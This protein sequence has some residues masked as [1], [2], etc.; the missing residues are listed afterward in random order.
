MNPQIPKNI[1]LVALDLDDTTLRTDKRI[2]PVTKSALEKA[3]AAGIELVVASGRA[4]STLPREILSIPGIRYAIT[5]NG[6]ALYHIPTGR[7]LQHYP[8]SR[9]SI[10]AL[11][12]IIAEASVLCEAF[13]DGVP[14]ADAAFVSHPERYGCQGGPVVQYIQNTRIP[15][16]DMQAFIRSR[17]DQIDSIDLR[18][19]TLEEKHRL[20]ELLR[21]GV[22]GVY[23]TSSVPHLLEIADAKAGKA[24]G[25]RYLNG[26]LGIGPEQTAAFGNADN[27]VDML[28]YAGF[29]VAVANAAESCL[30]AADY[31]TAANDRDGVALVL[32]QLSAETL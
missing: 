27:D 15:E 26:L 31:V 21:T 1:R 14:H 32:N 6:A 16:A 13:V 20:T 17:M 25:L 2:S 10:E 12:G 7:R 4:F 22:P 11:L 30:A 23:I 5:S 24:A 9:P 18:C 29:G 28:T 19:A 3:L 8:L